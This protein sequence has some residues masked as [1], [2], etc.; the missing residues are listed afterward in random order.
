M[1]GSRYIHIY[2]CMSQAKTM[3]VREKRSKEMHLKQLSLHLW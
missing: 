3:R 2:V 1:C